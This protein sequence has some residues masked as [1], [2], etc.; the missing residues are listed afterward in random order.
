M[1]AACMF[2]AMNVVDAE[3]CSEDATM[4]SGYHFRDFSFCRNECKMILP[5]GGAGAS[6]QSVGFC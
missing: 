3:A 1:A 5:A 6:A 2:T 4:E